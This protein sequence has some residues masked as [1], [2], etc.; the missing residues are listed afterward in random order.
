MCACVRVCVRA[1]VR[2]LLCALNP[3]NNYVHFEEMCKRLGPV[4]V[5]RSKYPVLLLL[6]Y[7]SIH[8]YIHIFAYTFSATA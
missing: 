6:N 8:I 1:C 4:R 3:E 5:R 2:V 7:F